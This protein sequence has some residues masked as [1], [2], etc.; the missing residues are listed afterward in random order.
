[1]KDVFTVGCVICVEVKQALLNTKVGVV[2]DAVVVVIGGFSVRLCS[3]C[4]RGVFIPGCCGGARTVTSLEWD[5]V[6]DGHPSRC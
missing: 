3:E 2:R 6:D 1:M 4:A 5:G